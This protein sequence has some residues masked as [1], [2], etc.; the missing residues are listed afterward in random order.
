[1]NYWRNAMAEVY[2]ILVDQVSGCVFVKE[3]EFFRSQGGL[4][5]DW[6]KNWK[7]ILADSIEDAR[8]EWCKLPGA[9]SYENQAK[10]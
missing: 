7:P 2:M 10:P 4:K 9:K 6:G 5:Q 8:E 1:M 3:L